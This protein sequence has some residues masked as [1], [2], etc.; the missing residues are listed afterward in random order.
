MKPNIKVCVV[1]AGPSGITAAKNCIQYGLDVV[2]FEKNDKVGGNWVFN[3]KTGHSS[4][5][6]NT[7]IIS[8]KVWSEYEDYPMPEDYPEY[9][10]HKQLQA[11]FESYS[12]HFG[13]YKKIR[14]NHTIQKI[15]RMDDGNW[16]VEYLDASKKK[17]VEVFDVLMVANG[18]HWNPKYPEYPGKF[19]GKFIHS[20]DFKGVTNEWKGKDVLVIGG[21]NSACDVAVESAR[22]ANTVKLSM[23]SPQWFFPKFLF[24]MPSD[25]FAATT[26]SWIPAKI[27]Q[28][29]L[30]KLLHILQGPYKNYGLPENTTLALS[31]HP[32]LNSDLL[33]FI[34]HGRIKPRPAIKALHGKE[35]EFV[36]GVRERFDIICACTGF[37]TTFPFFDKSFIDFQYVEKI[38]LFR[39]M[40]HNDYKNL[41]FIGLFQPV[42]CIW[43]MADYQAKLACMEILGKYERPKDLK[44]AIKYEI[45]HPHFSFGGGQRHAVEVDYHAFR[46]ELK[47]ELLKAGIDIGK[48]P[49]GKKSLYKVYSKVVSGETAASK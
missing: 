6:E 31:H 44:A 10:N 32:T 46:K 48:P 30:T 7:H 13:V 12:K 41:Y 37:W 40:M 38:P 1:G 49:G 19:T 24:G 17:K 29:A 28:F 39:K 35:V 36:N 18:H 8:S 33:D 21:G 5:Y 25:V 43:P 15:T 22:V 47:A 34:R 2:V 3:S 27:K 9:P 45:E 4:V 26:P 16:K 23:R 11:Y 42:G 14:F 20:H